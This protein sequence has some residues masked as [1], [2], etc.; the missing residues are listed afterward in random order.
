MWSRH[1][2]G[3]RRQKIII[4][5]GRLPALFVTHNFLEDMALVMCIAAL[6]A[7]ICQFLRQPLVVGYLV[8]GMV[9]GPNVPGVYANLERVRLVAELGVRCWFSRL[10][11]NSTFADSC[12]LPRLPGW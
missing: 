5:G 7:V 6:A 11:L 3:P 9:V 2:R 10:A 4:L 8:A 12:D 1:G